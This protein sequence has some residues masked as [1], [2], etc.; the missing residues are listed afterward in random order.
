MLGAFLV[1][2]HAARAEWHEER[3]SAA[4]PRRDARR[5]EG[6]QHPPRRSRGLHALSER[7][8]RPRSP[9]MLNAYFERIVPLME[10][11]GGEVHQI[12]GDELMVVFDKHDEPDHP[13]RAARAACSCSAR[14]ASRPRATPTGRASESACQQRR[15]A[16][17]RR[18]RCERAPQARARR[19]R[20]QPRRAAAGRGARRRRPDR[21][22]ETYRLLGERRDRRGASAA[23]REGEGRAHCRLPSSRRAQVT[24]RLSRSTAGAIGV[25]ALAIVAMFFD[26]MLDVEEAFPADWPAFAISVALIVIVAAFVFGVVV[27]RTTASPA[28]ADLAGKRGSSAASSPCWRFPGSGSASRSCSQGAASR[29]ECSAAPVA[30]G[31]WQLRRSRSVSSSSFSGSSAPTGAAT[32]SAWTTVN[33]FESTTRA[34]EFPCDAT[35]EVW[36]GRRRP[37]LSS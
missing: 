28:A 20:R 5:R 29:S 13:V 15:G 31:A 17:G 7:T 24:T 3:F 11:A 6:R 34:S 25:T 37:R 35:C 18:G 9:S 22:A 30:G 19:R 12:V 21:R 27:R 33:G 14:R 10:R 16:R 4:L 1:I 8:S 36:R 2:A 26:H 23:A 32:A